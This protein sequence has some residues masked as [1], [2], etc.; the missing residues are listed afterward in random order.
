[1]NVLSHRHHHGVHLDGQGIGSCAVDDS[2]HFRF[3]VRLERESSSRLVAY[4]FV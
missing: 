3:V 4:A 1:M 2:H